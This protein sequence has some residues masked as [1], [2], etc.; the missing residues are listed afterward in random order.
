M[1][2]INKYTQT[3]QRVNRVSFQSLLNRFALIILLLGSGVSQSY[4]QVTVSG[5]NAGNGTY[6][7]LQSAFA[8][9]NVA[10]NNG[11]GPISVVLSAN[12]TETG[13]ALLDNFTWASVTVTATVPVTIQ[14]SVTGAIIKLNGAD[15]VTIDGRIGGSGRNITVQNN[16]TATATAA[17]WLASV[18]AGNGA[19]NNTI[20]NLELACG[21]TQNTG[22]NVT[23]GIIMS[24]TTILITSNGTDNDNNTFRDNRIIRCR[25]GIV[26]R[27]TTTNLNE[28]IQV[29]NNIIGPASFGPDEIGKAGIY[30]QADNNSTVSGNTVQNVG[31][32]FANTSGGADRVGIAI[33]TDSWSTS[34]GTITSSNYTIT[35]NTILNVVEERTF[36]AVGILLATTNGGSPTNN[37]VANNFINNV[38]SNGTSGDQSVGIAISGGHTDR[39]VYNTIRMAGDVDPNPSATATSNFGSGIRIGLA[40]STSFANLTLRNNIVFMD[41]FSSSTPAARYYAISGPSAAYSFGTGG[42][43]HNDYYINPL[44]TQC[45]TG[46]L[47]TV[48]GNALGTQFATLANWQTAY[49]TPQDA[50]SIQVDPGFVSASDLHISA[51]STTVNNLGTPIAGVTTDFDGDTRSV[52]TPDIG[53]DEY[54]PV[55][56]LAASGG[57]ITPSTVSR[58]NGQTYTMTAAGAEVGAGITY[59]WEISSTGGGVGFSN[60]SGG[61]GANTASYTTG[62]LTPGV[63][64]YRLRVDCSNGPVTGYSDELTVTV[65]PNPV[66]SVDVPAANYCNPN[67][68]AVTINA[69]GASTYTWAPASGLDVATGATVISSPTATTTYTVT[70]TDGNGC[71]ATAT[72][73]ITVQAGMSISSITATPSTVCSGS[74]SQLQVTAAAAGANTAAGTIYT[75]TTGTFESIPSPVSLTTPTTGTADDGFTPVNTTGSFVFNYNGTN[76]DNFVIS[77]NGYVVMGATAPALNGIVSS[78]TS[79]VL[80]G[81]NAVIGYGRDG[82]INVTNGGSINHGLDV[83]GTK[84][85]FEYFN[86]ATASGGAES[87]TQYGS[88]Q[89]VLWGNSSPIPGRIELIYGTSVGT[90]ATS[91]CIGLRDASGTSAFKNGLTGSSTVASTTTTFPVDQ[92]RFIFERQTYTY[93]WT[94]STFIEGQEALSNPL[95]T[96]VTATT[97]YAVTVTAA[98]GC[99][100]SGNVTVTAEPLACT[101]ATAGPVNCANTNFTVT[102]NHTGGGAPYNYSWDDGVGGVYPNSATITVNLPA[103]SYTLTC[104]VTDDC[105]SNCTSDVSVTVND[106]PITTVTPGTGLI[107]NPSG[108]PVALSAAGASTY[109]WSPAAGLSA[110]TG[111]NVTAN[112]LATTSYTVTGTDGNGCTSTATAVITV[113][114]K[115]NISTSA[116]PTTVCIGDASTLTAVS[117]TTGSATI[118]TVTTSIGGV[119]GNPYRSGN[120]VGNQIRTQLLYTAA[121]LMAAGVQPGPISSI[122][123]T[124]QSSSS[125]TVVNLSIGLA[126]TNITA[127]TSTFETT[128]VTTVFTQAT[129]TPLASGLN[130]HVFNAGTFSWDGVSSILVNVCQTNSVIGTATVSAFTPAT[131]SN[132]HKASATTSCTDLT[133]VTVASKPIA[134]F[135]WTSNTGLFTWEWQPGSLSGNSVSVNPTSTTTYTVTA[136]SAGGC[137]SSATVTVNANP[138]VTYYQD[139]DVDGFGNLAMSQVSC[140]GAPSG[141]V[142]DNTDCNDANAGINPGAT[143]ICNNVDDDCDGSTDEGFDA[144]GDGFTICNG[145]CDDNNA[146]VYPGAAEVCNGIDDNCN[147]LTDD[148]TTPLSAPASVTGP[149]TAC[150]PG[151]AGTASFSTSAVAG[152]TGY[153]WTVPAGMTI[154]SGQGTTTINVAYTN[155]AIQN[156]ISGQLC[157]FASNACV[158]SAATCVNIDYQVAAPVTPNSIS[159]PGKVCPGDVATY[160]VAAVARATSY[161]WSVPT[162][163]TVQSGQGTNIVSVQVNAGY[164][165]GSITVTASNVCGTS[166]ARTRSLTLNL[167]GTPTAI[168]GQ[169]EGLCNTTGNVYSITVVP[170]ATSYN[171]TTTGATI[172]AGNG[173]TSIIADVAL[174]T[175]TG[176]ITVQ[177]VNG[178][179]TS[180]VRSLTI[181]GAPAR[182]GVISGATAVCSGTTEPYSVATV[183]GASTYN[184]SVTANG[185]IA[186]GQGTKNITTTWGSAAGGQALNVTTSNACG[187][188]LT[189]SLSGITISSCPRL[190]DE[191][192]NLQMVIMP[193]PASAFANV[194]FNAG[195]TGDYRLRITDITG[196]VVFMQ[197]ANAGAGVNTI[198]LDLSTYSS[199]IYTVELNFNGEQ[200]VSRMMVE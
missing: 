57:N 147:G 187:T 24:G 176:T 183:A 193:N 59:Q 110:A 180:L 73:V 1:T 93:V 165:G 25:Y 68:T 86:F 124:T 181:S 88:F 174:L 83:S 152:A 102:A 153:A 92:T 13:T 112:P 178:C 43:N 61:I 194:Q 2:N 116:S 195:E 95:A 117:G 96:G 54:T 192:S 48:S 52:T 130:N 104:T 4:A 71:T 137:T 125:G 91:A 155:V 44:N 49:T 169:K 69:S 29:L 151:V 196:R 184:W 5:A 26:T 135:G 38:K 160:S 191:F 189:R 170:A 101:P 199:G 148:N 58:C 156:G 32:D 139:A 108:S 103:G 129:F 7:T 142:T 175:G 150:L 177:A 105:G 74:N 34:P 164:L 77:T 167:P 188:S 81:F 39:V 122:G 70:G 36:S 17:I 143:E 158:N 109:A 18:A 185:T 120:G 80:T 198:A 98:N 168:A 82:N 197:D 16:S 6:T 65:N 141:Y 172:T 119:N 23:F 140:V 9:I 84:Y 67:G 145:D 47:G 87:A 41:L 136:T 127:L 63:Y 85:V 97:P 89:I 11:S 134:T 55:V 20:R 40:S 200:Q 138:N 123:F 45:V 53:A 107:C 179:G 146:S 50:N 37:L 118:G 128:P 100:I 66:V 115:A 51:G 19:T 21:A 163:M 30:M 126:N 12:T 60:V 190:S 157:V 186:T 94:P 132:N 31:G 149:A 154:T 131:T 42:Q 106:N 33:G 14:G 162:G 72:S 35:R 111:D 144:D 8:A 173:T 166:P 99:S 90:P 79:T 28:N 15:N 76:Y 46:G 113:N 10:G 27:G 22:T 62:A 64:Y 171:W 159:G 133:G 161:T 182:P 3:V 75:A 56:C 114:L 78:L 121:E